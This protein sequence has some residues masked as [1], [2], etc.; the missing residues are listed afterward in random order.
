MNEQL[1]EADRTLHS[2]AQLIALTGTNRLP[3]Q[4]DDSQANIGW[5]KDRQRLE[6]RAF[7]HGEQLLRL[8][9]DLPTFSLHFLDENDQPAASLMVEGKTPSDAGTWWRTLLQHW[10]FDT[11]KPVNYQL[12]AP[13]IP[14]ETAY[15]RPAGLRDWANW[16]T[17][18]NEQLAILN[19]HNGRA[20]D[21]RIWPHHFD[22]GVYYSISDESGAE[23]A[24]IWAGYSIADAVCAEPYFYLAGYNSRSP[25]DFGAA[26]G[27]TVG[28]WL[29]TPDWQGACLPVSNAVEPEQITRFFGD[30][31]AWVAAQVRA[32]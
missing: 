15:V 30:S 19:A 11:T 31:Y 21:I 2:L 14:M 28:Q 22:T 3:A 32:N 5:N 29:N 1:N 25:I 24:A 4:S 20:S 7:A 18:A 10:G 13:P 9:I 12:D 16:R 6:G 26:T 27:L 8:V 23:Q 17:V